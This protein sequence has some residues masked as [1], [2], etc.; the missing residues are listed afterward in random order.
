MTVAALNE[1]WQRDLSWIRCINLK[2]FSK[3]PYN[4]RL[5][6]HS[7]IQGATSIGNYVI[8]TVIIFSYLKHAIDIHIFSF[9]YEY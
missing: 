1:D 4:A 6:M 8:G 2:L 7:A 3:N 9:C 5:K